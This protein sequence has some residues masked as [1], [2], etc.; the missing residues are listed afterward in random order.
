MRKLWKAAFLCTVLVATSP[1]L[2][3]QQ[4]TGTGQTPPAT[5][6]VA[7]QPTQPQAPTAAG[8]GMPTFTTRDAVVPKGTATAK[9]GKLVEVPAWRDSMTFA[10]V[11]AMVAAVGAIALVYYVFM[12]K[13]AD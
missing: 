1:L 3:A 9:A 13:R 4:P 10:I 12:R 7:A 8:A 6:T 2:F 11:C 5:P